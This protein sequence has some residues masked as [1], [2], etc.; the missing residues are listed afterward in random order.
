MITL[1]NQ[2]DTISVAHI[3]RHTERDPWISA[4][5][6]DLLGDARGGPS[7]VVCLKDIVAS[8]YGSSRS[9]WFT[10]EHFPASFNPP[11][12]P[13]KSPTNDAHP[14][15]EKVFPF[16]EDWLEHL[17]WHFG[18]TVPRTTIS[19]GESL[20]PVPGPERWAKVPAGLPAEPKKASDPN[21]PT[22]EQAAIEV[23]LLRTARKTINSHDTTVLGIRK[24]AEA[25]NLA[26]T[27]AWKFVKSFRARQ[28]VE[29]LK[30]EEEESAYETGGVRGNSRWWGS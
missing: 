22:D 14:I 7:R 11:P 23:E 27:E 21:P 4:V 8:E 17:D 16:P 20:P 3:R 12:P 19:H 6:R 28:V 15:E 1:T 13:P 25:W 9:L 10:T 26:D 24:V 5:T 2:S 30:F 29:R 18:F